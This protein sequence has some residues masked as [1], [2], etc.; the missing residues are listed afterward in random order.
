MSDFPRSGPSSRGVDTTGHR[1]KRTREHD[2]LRAL[3]T[4]GWWRGR[5][6]HS[7]GINAKFETRPFASRVTRGLDAECPVSQVTEPTTPIRDI[8]RTLPQ[9]VQHEPA[10]QLTKRD[11]RRTGIGVKILNEPSHSPRSRSGRRDLLSSVNGLATKPYWSFTMTIAVD[12]Q[13]ASPDSLPRAASGTYPKLLHHSLG[14][15]H[16]QRK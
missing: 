15:D 4:G 9:D 13:P 12:K 14:R 11:F 10:H 2:L 8:G 1:H 6:G 7:L 16:E 5:C 3:A